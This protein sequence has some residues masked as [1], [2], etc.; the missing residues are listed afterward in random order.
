MFNAHNLVVFFYYIQSI[1]SPP[2]SLKFYHSLKILIPVSSHFS[3]PPFL[4]PVYHRP[5]FSAHAFAWLWPFVCADVHSEDCFQGLQC[6][7][8][9]VFYFLV[10]ANVNPSS[11][12][13]FT[14]WSVLKPLLFMWW[15]V[16]H[17]GPCTCFV[18]T[19]PK[20]CV[21]PKPYF[22]F[23]KQDTRPLS[24]AQPDPQLTFLLYSQECRY[25]PP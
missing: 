5:T 17:S 1:I 3:S 18:S 11:T 25:A 7:L 14:T 8:V 15:W 2:S 19:L 23:Y 22:F 6:G 12:H 4:A 13:S 16:P 20:N 9:S 21:V 24:V 10:D